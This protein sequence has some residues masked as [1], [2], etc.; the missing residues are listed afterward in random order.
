MGRSAQA[1]QTRRTAMLIR[2]LLTVVALLMVLPSYAKW[3]QVIDHAGFW[4]K[5]LLLALLVATSAHAADDS[6]PAYKYD[7]NS[8]AALEAKA[9]V[10][11]YKSDALALS[12]HDLNKEL[13]RLDAVNKSA[14][15]K[16]LVSL[17][18]EERLFVAAF[19]LTWTDDD[20]RASTYNLVLKKRG[21][22]GDP[23]ASLYWAVREWSSIC[24]M[25]QKQ[26]DTNYTKLQTEC[27]QSLVPM[28][29]KASDAGIPSASFNI[30][31]L[32]KFGYG[33]TPSKLVAADWYIRATEQSIKLN[34]RHAA[35]TALEGALDLVPDHPAALRLRKVMLK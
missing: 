34:D 4:I 33:V 24:L 31:T 22:D 29:K 10:D 11:G 21:E 32:Y 35:L 27:W 3:A 28:F 30:A 14:K 19:G 20:S 16:E 26:T 17:K 5:A 9:K 13:D 25:W 7:P 2:N 6:K 23:Y 15:A 18:P 12:T 1:H 8:P